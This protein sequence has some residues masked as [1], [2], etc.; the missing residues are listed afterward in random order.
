MGLGVRI[1]SS[2]FIVS[3]KG[4]EFGVRVQFGVRVAWG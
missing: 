2:G 3:G 1:Q 4:S